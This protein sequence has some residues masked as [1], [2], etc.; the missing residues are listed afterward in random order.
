MGGGGG[1]RSNPSR[2]SLA[3]SP[4]DMEWKT[5]SRVGIS[6]A[7]L[8]TT[9]HRLQESRWWRLKKPTRQEGRSWKKTKAESSPPLYAGR[10]AGSLVQIFDRKSAQSYPRRWLPESCPKLASKGNSVVSGRLPGQ[11]S[12]SQDSGTLIFLSPQCFFLVFFKIN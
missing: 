9:S 2:M 11:Q 7:R 12:G 4:G 5:L 10:Q 8:A 6:R 1:T 3:E